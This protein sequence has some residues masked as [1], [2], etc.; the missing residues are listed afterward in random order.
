MRVS[1]T[2]SLETFSIDKDLEK[3]SVL[4]LDDNDNLLSVVTEVLKSHGFSVNAYKKASDAYQ[5]LNENL[6]DAIVC[7]IMMPEVDG[8]NF[9]KNLMKDSRFI[10]IPFIFLT[11]VSAPDEIRR[12]KEFGC[13]D[14]MI[15]PFNPEEL[16]SVVRGK[17]NRKEIRDFAIKKEM[18][19][20]RRR[21]IHTLSHEFRT[22][23]VAV[24]T[25]SEL[26]KEQYEKLDKE[27]LTELIE[28]VQRGG[29]RLQSLVDDFMILQQIDY[30]VAL[31]NQKHYKRTHS[32][33]DVTESA[34]ERAVEENSDGV[35]F[36]VEIVLPG[37]GNY[38]VDIFDIQVV[39][40]II[41]ILNNAFKFGGEENKVDVYFKSTESSVSVIVR[42]RGPGI[43]YKH[44]DLALDIFGQINRDI[45]EQQGCGLGLPIAV[46]YISINGGSVSLDSIE[47]DEGGAAINIT[48]PLSS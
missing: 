40:A 11:A 42:D 31:S 32:L 18:E 46:Y 23:L 29:A 25:G 43:S 41:R 33:V 28:S 36:D 30:G 10:S 39:D 13:D 24:N 9:Y 38:N 16:V 5:F 48:F 2:E 34:V 27:K 37:D 7:D 6:P 12:V 26:L 20:Q 3:Y 4:V 19:E 1:S 8:V 21:I 14:Y 15:K 22:P 35:I 17:I 45:L 47:D 44:I